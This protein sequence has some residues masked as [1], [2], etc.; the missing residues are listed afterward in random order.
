MLQLNVLAIDPG[1]T[2]TKIGAW[3]NG[4][5]TKSTIYHPKELIDAFDDI[6]SQ[7]GM[8]LQAIR[9]FLAKNQMDNVEFDAVVGRGGLI[10][11]LRSGVY[12]V[13][14]AMLK[15]LNKGYNGQH[16]SNLGGILAS[17]LAR[18]YGCKAFIVDPVVVDEMDRIAR[19][20]G[21]RQIER[22]S[23]FHAL[24]QKAVA[25]RA[26]DRLGKRYEDVNLIVA[27][28]G[29]GISVGLHRKGR[30]SDVNNALDG[31]G[32]FAVNR[33][34]GLPVGDLLKLLQSG[35]YSPQQLKDTISRAGGVYSYLGETDMRKIERM[36][37]DG[38]G[39]ANEVIDAMTYQV[40]KE[41]GA[42]A[43]AAAGSIDGV[44]LTGGLAK[45][46]MIVER[47]KNR[48][49]FIARVFVFPGEFELEALIEASLRALEGKEPIRTYPDK[50][51]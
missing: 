38:N 2:S 41:I 22:R 44:V 10:R 18:I 14:S 31:D 28:L 29:G 27:H 35:E 51:N 34:G 50:E 36:I 43:V 45:S 16:A 42:L 26:A 33:S 30:V 23:I 17:E 1:S 3:L 8:R 48:V 11:P 9:E 12:E 25:R 46:N 7:K 37:E 20:S 24:N 15:D 5:L 19:Y 13:N 40:A 47:I 49:A 32:P 21:L 4:E 6:P 39:Y